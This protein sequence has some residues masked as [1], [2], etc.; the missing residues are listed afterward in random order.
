MD[1]PRSRVALV[2]AGKLYLG[3][4][5][6]IPRGPRTRVPR[7]LGP[8]IV[9]GHSLALRP[10]RLSDASSWRE[11]R[12]RDKQ[13]IESFWVT[14]ELN[15]TERHTD[16]S[17]VRECLQMRRAARAGHALPLVIEIDGQFAGQCNLE[18][19]D[20]YSRTAE[21]GIW[22]DSHASGKGNATAAGALLLDH[23]FGELALQRVTAPIRIDNVAT[24]RG[25]ERL[26][27]RHEGTM[28]GFLDVGGRIEDH[29]LW[30]MT[31]KLAPPGGFVHA[32]AT[33]HV[34]DLPPRDRHMGSVRRERA[35]PTPPGSR[36]VLMTVGRYHL[37]A[38]RRIDLHHNIFRRSHS[39][40]RLRL[41]PTAVDG[42][43]VVLRPPRLS[44]ASAWSEI[45]LRDR[46]L[47][48]PFWVTSPQSWTQR[49]TETMWVRECLLMRRAARAGHALPL[50][51]EID[52]QF[53]GQ[54][55][56]E[57]I[58]QPSRTAEMGIWLDSE[59]AH[60]GVGA[61]AT[62]LLLEHAFDAL[63]IHRITAPVCTGNVRA[64]HLMQ[65]V[66]M[67]REA[68]MISFLD[69]GGQRRD[70]D[71]WAVTS[72]HYAS[73]PSTTPDHGTQRISTSP[74]RDPA[75]GRSER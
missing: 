75:G 70:H 73:P 50:V 30:A 63:R 58:D 51:I 49:H 29:E 40:S 43:Q 55:N 64:A 67:K 53:A 66:G 31:P 38:F 47:I 69:V 33:Q 2:A 15:W 19:I 46:G 44:D 11:I 5:R 18:R 34:V 52:G 23:A 65:R 12:L 48:E 37:R 22:L 21:A 26:G 6:Q 13:M 72:E 42:T 56:L 1:A 41:G 35:L 32:L 27:F 61:A 25:A 36:A 54:C 10:P 14:S 17:W 71:L 59:V 45:R 7:S 3:S 62:S 68:T 4:L 60:R 16:V 28:S 24:A 20:M 74:G 39:S 8:L 9:A 57:R